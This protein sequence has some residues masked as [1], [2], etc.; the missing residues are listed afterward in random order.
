M[1][2]YYNIFLIDLRVFYGPYLSHTLSRE[3]GGLCGKYAA[4]V[5]QVKAKEAKEFFADES[6]LF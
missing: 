2:L 1:Y 4:L 6:T 3:E 5:E